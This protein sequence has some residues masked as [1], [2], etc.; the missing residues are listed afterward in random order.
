MLV[1]S[2][3]LAFQKKKKQITISTNILVEFKG[4]LKYIQNYPHHLI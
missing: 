3:V 2:D 1:L 4:V